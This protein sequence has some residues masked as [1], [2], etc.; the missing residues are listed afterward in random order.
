[1]LLYFPIKI[2]YRICYIIA[3]KNSSKKMGIRKLNKFL[4]NKNIYR[5]YRNINEFIT[6]LNDTNDTNKI[7]NNSQNGKI[8]IAID[9]WLYAHKF[10]HSHKSDNVFSGFWNQIMKFLF[11]GVIPFYVIDGSVPIEKI[12]KIEDRIKKRDNCKQ[13]ISIINDEIE[14]Y[15]NINDIDVESSIFTDEY[16]DLMY[17]KKEKL[18]RHIKR[19]KSNELYNIYKM[20]DVLNIPYM[21][22]KFEA[23]ALC[24][25]L[26]KEKIISC[27]LSDDMDM[28]TLGCGSTIKFYEGKI[29]EF[30][31]EHVK[32][33]LGLSQ[34][35]FID[36]CI[37]FGCDYLHH[38]L[39]MDCEDVYNLIKK[40]GSLLDALCSNEHESFN[41]N[42][43]NVYVIGE[44]YNQVKEYYLKSCDKE[45]IPEKLF[46][47]KMKNINIDVLV[48]FLQRLR[49]FDNSEQNLKIIEKNIKNINKK[50]ELGD[51]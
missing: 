51:I 47:I 24:A 20:F 45:F 48:K 42:N 9:F 41:M 17:T 25:K 19:I 11:H 21:K 4:M 37:M 13:K 22:A 43:R 23:D 40:H 14:N 50:I 31:L 8:I 6:H 39:K 32:S 3:K 27:C 7:I 5:S 44:Q 28:L 2:I 46:D 29:I 33:T 30:D 38:S 1:M 26:Y 34:E 35:Q 15:I 16:L 36:V 18:Q 10:L 12:N 49:W